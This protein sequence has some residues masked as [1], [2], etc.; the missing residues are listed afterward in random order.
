M[1]ELLLPLG[2]LLILAA[3]LHDVA[4][5]TIP[6]RIALAVALLGLI[7]HG[8]AGDLHWAFLAAGIVFLLC[9]IAWRL[10]A[11]GGGDVKLLAACALLA[12]PTAVP[13]LILMTALAG[14]VL[15]VIYI[16]AR[17]LV[18]P[19]AAPRP[20][21]LFRRLLRA[22]AWRMR[23]GGPLPYGVAIL[24]GAILTLTA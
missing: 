21:T 5:R 12:T 24:G 1:I 6:N 15:S 20:E 4:A 3:A 10:G 22:E 7:R 14:G 8:I 2:L 18:P 13:D 23:R 19:P 11:M 16:V 9:L 17:R